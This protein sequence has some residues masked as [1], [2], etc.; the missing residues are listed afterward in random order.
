M[1]TDFLRLQLD[2][3]GARGELAAGMTS[4]WLLNKVAPDGGGNRPVVTLP[5]FLASGRTLVRLNRFLNNNGFAAESWGLG[6]NLGPDNGGWSHK[7]DQLTLQ[8]GDKIRKLADR[9]GAHVA[10]VGQSLGGVYARELALQF[11]DV[12][13]RVIM[14]G[15]PTFHPY[16]KAHHNRVIALLGSW[17]TRQSPADLADRAGLLHWEAGQPPLPCVAIHSPIDSVI[18]EATSVIPQYIVDLK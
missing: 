8:F 3:L 6:R 1:L 10:L 4:N 15:S 17:M 16:I 13:D 2:L 9:N 12:I 11:P 5:G 7:L 14:L 18:H